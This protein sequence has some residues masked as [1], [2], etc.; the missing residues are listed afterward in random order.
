MIVR[1]PPVGSKSHSHACEKM[2]PTM[3]LGRGR[4]NFHG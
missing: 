3:D 4:G 1:E 2:V